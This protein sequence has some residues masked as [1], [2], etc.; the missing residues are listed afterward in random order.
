MP[1]SERKVNIKRDVLLTVGPVNVSD[2]VR[3]GLLCPDMCHREREFYDM[4]TDVRSKLVRIVGGDEDYTSVVFTGSGTASVEA[5]VCSVQGKLLTIINGAYGRRI[6]AIGERYGIERTSID[7]GFD[8]PR[9]D[10]IE[11]ALRNDSKVSH[12]AI[13]HNETTTGILNPV[14]EVGVLAKRYNKTLI[15]DAISSVG[16]HQLNLIDDNIDFCIGSP[17]KCLGGL[18][19]ISFVVAKKSELERL[20]DEKRRG[21]Y[22]DLYNQYRGEENMDIPFTFAIQ[23]LSSFNVALDEF[24]SEGLEN[25]IK[26]YRSLAG[27]LRD[28]LKDLGFKFLVET[29]QMSNVVTSVILPENVSY[30]Y[31]HDKLKER[32]FII[33]AGK[34]PFEDKSFRVG[35]MGALTRADVKNFLL[36]LGEIMDDSK[37]VA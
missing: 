36:C 15:V 16:G 33:Y 21:V 2:E 5:V 23:S 1:V 27:L 34:G 13:I 9:L 22:L 28:G 25:R 37:K 20:R 11:E 29:S 3:E 14:H 19:G 4:L 31:L 10:K 8:C 24:L 30:D 6:D 18:P 35:N 12:V 17:N 7:F 26:R 32:G